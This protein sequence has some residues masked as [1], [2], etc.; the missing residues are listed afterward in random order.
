MAG[1]LAV[2][3]VEAFGRLPAVLPGRVGAP[4]ASLMQRPQSYFGSY[5]LWGDL[6]ALMPPTMR[7]VM[8]R[9]V[10]H[11]SNG[12]TSFH[13]SA[14]RKTSGGSFQSAAVN[15]T[16]VPGLNWSGSDKPG[17]I[18]KAFNDTAV[19]NNRFD[20]RKAA[21]AQI[22]KIPRPLSEWIARVYKPGAGPA[23]AKE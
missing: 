17:Y 22:A 11:R 3:A 15:G 14:A 23:E 19:K 13:G 10:A 5:Y 2:P 12:E 18:A 8:K 6:P 16:K 4:L 7:A 9:G 21:S 20:S 1:R